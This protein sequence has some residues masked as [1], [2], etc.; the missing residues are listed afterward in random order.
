[1]TDPTPT[2]PPT[3]VRCWHCTAH[4]AY[5]QTCWAIPPNSDGVFIDAPAQRITRVTWESVSSG[6]LLEITPAEAHTLLATYPAGQA[7][8][9]RIC[10]EHPAVE[11]GVDWGSASGSFTVAP[12]RAAPKSAA[13]VQ[14]CVPS[15]TPMEN[16]PKILRQQA[17]VRQAAKALGEWGQPPGLPPEPQDNPFHQ[18][19]DS[20]VEAANLKPLPRY[21]IWYRWGFHWANDSMEEVTKIVEEMKKYPT[22]FPGIVVTESLY[23]SIRPFRRESAGDEPEYIDAHAAGESLGV[24]TPSTSKDGS[25]AAQFLARHTDIL[26]AT[27][28]KCGGKLLLKGTRFSVAQLIAEIADDDAALDTVCG[29]YDLHFE[30][31]RNA[32][33]AVAAALG[34]PWPSIAER[35]EAAPPPC[36]LPWTLRDDSPGIAS[37]LA[38]DGRVVLTGLP[39]AQAWRVLDAVNEKPKEPK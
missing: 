17:E 12:Q 7:E 24:S 9:L 10:R 26:E 11:C 21:Q 18:E 13:V 4:P 35:W 29:Q 8:L 25:P 27:P 22:D 20:C 36:P 30:Q 38:A 14:D 2:I 15:D 28:G 33:H 1:M 3:S 31:C 16:I 32:L 19:T 34:E 23:Q 37:I 5:K 6:G 39:R